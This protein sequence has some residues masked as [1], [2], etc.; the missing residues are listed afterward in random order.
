VLGIQHLDVARDEREGHTEAPVLTLFGLE[1]K[2]F[3]LTPVSPGFLTA[4]LY[5]SLQ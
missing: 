4:D 2:T 5:T 1:P 3:S